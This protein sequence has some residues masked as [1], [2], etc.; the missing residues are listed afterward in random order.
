MISVDVL[1][2][3]QF[4]DVDPMNVVWHGNYMKY[5][6]QARCALLEQIGYNY[7]A[8]RASGFIWPIVDLKVRYIRPIRSFQDIVVR[9][10]VIEYLNRLKIEYVIL[11]Q[12]TSEVLT[13]AHT[14]QV[15]VKE[16][17]GELFIETPPILAERLGMKTQ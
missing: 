6:E 3:A 4:Y 11:D 16:E 1:I 13:R 7:D 14:V 9:A 12:Q 15:A 17:T 5:F 8:M 2:K 10:E